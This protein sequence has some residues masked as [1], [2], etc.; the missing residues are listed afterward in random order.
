[1]PL[2]AGIVR[3]ET[4]NDDG[5]RLAERRIIGDAEM[6]RL[7]PAAERGDRFHVGHAERRFDQRFEADAGLVALRHLDLADERSTI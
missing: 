5:T 3:I 6:Q 7:E 1:M 2:V 4:T